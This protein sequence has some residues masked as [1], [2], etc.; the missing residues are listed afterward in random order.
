MGESARETNRDGEEEEE[1]DENETE[2]ETAYL[3]CTH[4]KI[5]GAVRGL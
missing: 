2:M 4:E 1:E 3:Q 5:K